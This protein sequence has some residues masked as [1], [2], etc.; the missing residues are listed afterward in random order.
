MPGERCQIDN[1]ALYIS[2]QATHPGAGNGQSTVRTA[3][4]QDGL[5]VVH[6]CCPVQAGVRVA[7]GVLAQDHEMNGS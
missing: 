7:D 3:T 2:M 1:K 6:Q 4:R 5:D